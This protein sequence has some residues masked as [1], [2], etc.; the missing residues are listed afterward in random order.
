LIGNIAQDSLS[1]ISLQMIAASADYRTNIGF[2]EGTGA[3]VNFVARLLDGNNN[4]LNSFNGSLP[5]FGHLQRSVPDLFGGVSLTDGRVEVEV[6][7]AAGKVS[8]YASVL[9]NKTNDPLMVFPAQPA[10]T[11]AERYVLAGIAE[12]VGGSN[13]HSDMRMY[14][15]G[16]AAVTATLNFYPFSAETPSVPAVQITI[17]AG[18]VLA[19]DD[20]LPTLWP[21]LTGGG[22][23]VAT[24]NGPSSLVVTAQTFSLQPDGGTKGQFIPGVTHREAVGLGDR[25]LEILQL[26]QSDQYRSNVGF[27]EVTGKP[28]TIEVTAFEPDAKIS[29]TTQIPLKANEYTQYAR[30]LSSMGLGTVYNGRVSVK[31]VA[32]EGRVY[33][34][35]S[36][37][38]NRTED[39]TYVPAQ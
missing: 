17:N 1:R 2:V 25:P 14:N 8:A 36:T 29:V 20:V 35:G 9:N 6:N 27:V 16:S 13:F 31:V 19:V 28:V 32:G 26:E 4:V 33:A 37:V 34:Y 15:A 38:D 22:S 12:F 3:P 39:P 11:T 23:V 18:Q 30:M 7:S 21:G 24:T 10:R 5:P